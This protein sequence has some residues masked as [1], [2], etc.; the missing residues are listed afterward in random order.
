MSVQLFG[1]WLLVVGVYCLGV[2]LMFSG[3]LLLGLV[4]HGA[5]VGFLLAGTL[6]PASRL[7]GAVQT[8]CEK[9]LWLTLDD[10]P[11]PVDTPAI[12]DLLDEYEAKA[13]FFVIG[14][15]A[16][17]YPELIREIHRRGHQVGNHSWSHPQATFWM[18]GPV[19]TYREIAR[20]QDVIRGILGEAP[21]FFRAPVGHYNFF[22]HP[23]LTRFGLRLIGWNSRGYDG[24]K[25]R[26]ED[27]LAR[28]GETAKDGSIVLA[29]ESSPIAAEVVRGV[30]ELAR[31]Q[32]L[33]VR[34][35][36]A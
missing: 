10:G 12:L 5:V 16:A 6:N 3:Q 7:F 11:D 24:V 22:V 36:S 20:C 33:E 4:V 1:R 2:W 26:L 35:P 15:K 30:L 27:V 23:V 34:V 18:L 19:R 17:K 25:A 13:T 21:K 31:E 14:K 8:K 29:H 32:G 9:G 28:I